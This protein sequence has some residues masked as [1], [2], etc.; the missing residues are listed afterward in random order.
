MTK[1]EI[2]EVM[3]EM[4]CWSCDNHLNICDKHI[5]TD[6]EHEALTEVYRAKVGT[7]LQKALV[8]NPEA[9]K[10]LAEAILAVK[11]KAT[12]KDCGCFESKSGT[13]E[14]FCSK[15]EAKECN[16]CGEKTTLELKLCTGCGYKLGV[17]KDEGIATP[18]SKEC[19]HGRCT[20]C[21]ECLRAVQGFKQRN[22]IYS[23]KNGCDP[24]DF[25]AAWEKS[26]KLDTPPSKQTRLEKIRELDSRGVHDASDV[27]TILS[28]LATALKAL[29]AIS[30]SHGSDAVWPELD[31]G[32]L[33][34]TAKLAL[35]SI[36]EDDE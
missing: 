28:K 32:V 24:A 36:N 26:K 8:D 4:E 34:D 9:Q 30:K 33:I 13:V 21:G 23:C 7:P 25:T 12:P 5:F 2:K 6:V 17:I 16:N 19:K 29:E 35:K 10:Q 27:E 15:H 11:N 1:E 22:T 20:G 3:K 18:P 31:H 14:M